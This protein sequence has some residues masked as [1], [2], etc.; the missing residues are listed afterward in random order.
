MYTFYTQIFLDTE[1]IKSM[2]KKRDDYS[3]ILYLWIN[4]NLINK[5]TCKNDFDEVIFTYSL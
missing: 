4:E 5:N 3:V 2:F 1:Y